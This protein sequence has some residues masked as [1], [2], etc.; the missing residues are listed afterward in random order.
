VR[1]GINP[2]L[3]VPR[4][5]PPAAS[6]AASFQGKSMKSLLAAVAMLAAS[7]APAVAAQLE[8]PLGQVVL[9]VSGHIRN[10][11]RGDVAVFDLPMLQ[12]L[13]GRHAT[14]E[15]PWTNGLTSF[16]GPLLSAI[17]DAAGAHGHRIVVKALNDRTA[18]VPITDATDFPTMLALK[19][20]GDFMSARDKGPLFLIY[21]FD[22]HPELYG[23]KYF[24]RSVWQIGEIEV[25][26]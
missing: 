9:V 24:T 21:P 10:T 4:P 16:E 11:N 5:G 6:V 22:S 17:L 15:T 12:S 2:G 26:D 25:V 19:L 23:E 7:A 14:M 1:P 8:Y 18:E 3:S 20:N 13:A